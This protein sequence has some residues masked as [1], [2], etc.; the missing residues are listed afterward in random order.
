LRISPDLLRM[1][2]GLVIGMLFLIGAVG[3]LAHHRAS[4]WRLVALWTILALFCVVYLRVMTRVRAGLQRET[5]VGLALMAALPTV[6][7]ALDAPHSFVALYVYLGAAVGLTLPAR[8]ALPLIALTALI[9]AGIVGRDSS[10]SAAAGLTALAIGAMMAAFRQQVRTNIELRA[11]REDLARLA[12]AEERVRFAR[13]VHDLLGHSLSVVALKAELATKLIDRDPQAARRELEDVQDVARRALSD[14][15][16][17]V[18]GYRA[19][20]LDEA[21]DGA[22]SALA[23]AGIDCV[24]DAVD[25]TLPTDVADVFAWAVREGTTNVVRHSDA[26]RC[27]IRVRVDGDTAHLEIEDDGSFSGAPA[28]GNGLAG[29]RERAAR[30]QGRLEAGAAAAGGFALRLAVP[31]PA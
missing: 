30:V 12:V 5:V 23:A 2:M 3:D 10:A 14:V 21:L 28:G 22:R 26:R 25:P 1:R 16:D 31:L 19:F 8:R 18:A 9:A 24:I 6:A 13:D 11:A 20:D 15:R 17:A 4:T 29:L 27:A 7:F